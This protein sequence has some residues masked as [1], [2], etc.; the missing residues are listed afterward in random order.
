[1]EQL[2]RELSG[3]NYTAL[4]K[5][6]LMGSEVRLVAAGARRPV[7][8]CRGAARDPAR[9]VVPCPLTLFRPRLTPF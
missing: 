6:E 3:L 2:K 4:L 9:G 5:E 1:M 7:W 8:A